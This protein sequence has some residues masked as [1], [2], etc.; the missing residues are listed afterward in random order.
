MGTIK[1]GG[2]RKRKQHVVDDGAGTDKQTRETAVAVVR[3]TSHGKTGAY[4]KHVEAALGR[5]AVR[6]C[7]R[8]SAVCKLTT[9]VEIVKRSA[10][11]GLLEV[12]IAVGAGQ[13]KHGQPQGRGG[14]AATAPDDRPCKRTRGMYGSRL[15]VQPP[16]PA[17]AESADA[18]GGSAG[19]AWTR[20]VW[21]EATLRTGG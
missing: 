13:G 18:A 20:D 6:L 1:G 7:A 14:E 19:P 8:G 9:V 10:R 17:D 3:I 4:A 11:P 21:M 16:A 15:D 12:D 5:S 2:R